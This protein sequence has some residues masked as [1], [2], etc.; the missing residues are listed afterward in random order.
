MEI[1]LIAH[2]IRSLHNV[3]SLFRT[4][5]GAGVGKIYLTGYTGAPV[6]KFKRPQKEVA[7]VAL[8][9]ELSIPWEKTKD[10]GRLIARLKKDGVFV[11]ALEQSPQSISIFSNFHISKLKNAPIALVVG[12]EV[13]GISPTL[14]KQCDLA[15]QIPMFGQKESL[16]VVVAAGIALFKLRE[17]F[18]RV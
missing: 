15:L 4:A 3:G 13:R 18:S 8:G 16:N 5:D 6:D 1:Y 9:A 14:V 10:L 17:I 7:K 2:N 12:N 11:I